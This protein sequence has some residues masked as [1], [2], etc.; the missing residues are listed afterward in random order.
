MT[1][2]NDDTRGAVPLP[3]FVLADVVLLS[4]PFS[5]LSY[6]L[7]LYLPRNAWQIGM[8]VAAP[9]GKGCRAA[10]VLALRKEGEGDPPPPGLREL[11][12]PLEREP[13]L[14]PEYLDI[15]KQLALRQATSSGRILGTVLPATLRTGK[16]RIRFLDAGKWR[17]VPVASFGTMEDALRA[18]CST[19][20][21]CGNAVCLGSVVDPLENELCALDQDPPWPV[22]PRAARQIEVLEYL[23]AHGAVSR[24][25]LITDLGAQGGIALSL[26]AER[27]IVRIT[28]CEEPVAVPP[29]AKETIAWT[30]DFDLTEE[31]KKMLEAFAH[32][33]E[34][35]K[36]ETHLLHGVTGSG[37]SVVYMA[38][39]ALCLSR[40][41]SV[42]LLAPEVALAHKLY[43][44]AKVHLPDAPVFLYHGYQPV[45]ARDHTFRNVASGTPALMVG[46]R[47]AL[48]L[49]V[50]E[51]GAIIL[52]EEHDGSF[53][54]DEGLLYQAKE[55]A[56]YRAGRENALLILGSATPD[57][58][59]YY[60]AKSGLFPLHALPGRVGGG[61]LPGV[62]LVSVPRGLSA[63]NNSGILAPESVAALVECVSRG[64]QAV[65]LL[66]RRGYAPLMYC[67]SCGETLKCPH[68]SI[69]LT[70]HKMREKAVCHYCGHSEPFPSPCPSC[71][72]MHF[73]PMGEGTEKLEESLA[74][75]L[76]AG[77]RILR[78]DRDSTR[79]PGMV[80]SI[81]NS[82]AR[83]E[84]QVLVGTQMLSKGHHFPDVTLVIAADADLGLNLPDYRAA[85]RTFQLLVQASGRAGRGEK[86]GEVLIQTRDPEH[87]CWEYVKSGDY[88]GFYE[89]EIARR[90]KPRYPPFTRLALLRIS[91]SKDSPKGAALMEE[92]AEILK[93]KAREKGVT[94]L[95]PAP[96]PI[97]LIRN[98][99][100]YHCLIKAD[101]WNV[102]RELYSFAVAKCGG[103]NQLRLSLDIDPVNML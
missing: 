37:K 4:P 86:S 94:I 81:L 88:A 24:R 54:Q 26:L 49:P 16:A 51:L 82:F 20:W 57:V 2:N 70:Y 11:Y 103:S 25:K 71:G 43:A 29:A 30:A 93:A 74:P 73:L 12:W 28:A 13:L 75:K 48:F 10:V 33:I 66:N 76:A 23:Y 56:W 5:V 67:L 63:G 52:D 1:R 84:A 15:V 22:R 27:D 62:R 41:K 9:L 61:S 32:G 50:K 59:T 72:G 69:S 42:M 7:P 68:C 97:A 40:G 36:S 18:S 39:A 92:I 6:A 101:N 44:D 31:Q 17:D 87:Y 14:S 45:K 79:R 80:E 8:R 83:K 90:E 53:K 58:K 99:R 89:Q 46:T 95:G 96:A 102:V 35:G 38:L 85:E 77:M 100:R 34:S 78:L 55:V 19:A 65:I 21:M 3:G 91:F 98:M 64:D 47:S 60:A